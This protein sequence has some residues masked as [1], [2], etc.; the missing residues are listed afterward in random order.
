MFQV[1]RYGGFPSPIP[2]PCD[3]KNTRAR[4]RVENVPYITSTDVNQRRLWIST[5][6]ILHAASIDCA[7]LE[8]GF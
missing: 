8:R 4:W 5:K 6:F 7:R 1:F 3:T 2:Q